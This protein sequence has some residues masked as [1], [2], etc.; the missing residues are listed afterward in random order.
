MK[1]KERVVAEQLCKWADVSKSSFYYKAHPGE[2]GMKA[3]THT[4]IGDGIVENSQV[5][6]QIRV[7]LGLDYC[8]YGYRVM[9]SELRGMGYFINPKKVYRLMDEN[10]LLCGKKI[11]TKGK[12]AFVKFRRIKATKPMEYL[13]LDIKYVWVNGEGRQY[14]QLSIMDV[15]T[16][17]I[18]C[19][20]FQGSIKQNDVIGLM[21]G[22][23]LRF[24]LK[25]VI[26]RND[27][28]SQ[29]IAHK[30]RQALQ[31]ME[32]RQEFTHVA[33]PEENAYIESFHSI[34]QRELFDRFEFSSY[35]H[36]RRHIEKYMHWY[37]CVRRHGAINEQTPQ[38]MWDEY[39]QKT[40][41]ALSGEAEAVTA[42]EQPARNNLTN[43]DEREG[44]SNTVPS[45]PILSSS[46]LPM[47]QL[48]SNKL[49]L[50]NLN[51][52]EKS[53]QTMGG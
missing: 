20:I 13:C 33:T 10:R 36:A 11:K 35:Y 3:S 52:F 14:Y 45:F 40:K 7:I 22:L 1:F 32:A 6:E 12:R 43:G 34:Q 23:D 46:L 5:V 53:V 15:F 51:C 29:F 17:R 42:G 31:D 24:G 48:Y 37:N 30:V 21:R 19:W 26:I 38:Q 27:N 18:L 25:G 50:N 49:T 16:R 41:F 39:N 44:T 4:P 9:T 47:P 28:G 8:A 2:R